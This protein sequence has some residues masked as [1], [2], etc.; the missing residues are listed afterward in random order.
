MTKDIVDMMGKL[1]KHRWSRHEK[2][3]EID[4]LVEFGFKNATVDLEDRGRSPITGY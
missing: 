4:P 3:K 2:Q 1:N